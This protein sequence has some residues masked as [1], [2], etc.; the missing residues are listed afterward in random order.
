MKKILAAVLLGLCALAALYGDFPHRRFEF[1]FDFDAGASNNVLGLDKIFNIRK[2]VELDLT[3][4]KEQ[5]LRMDAAA[6]AGFFFNLKINDTY[7]IGF[8]AGGEGAGYGLANEELVRLLSRG[9][10][11]TRDFGGKIEGGAGVFVDAGLRGEARFGRLRLNLKPALFSPLIYIS[12]PDIHFENVFT[13]KGMHL[14]AVVDMD[15]YSA[16]S[17]EDDLSRIGF[18][19][20]LPLGFDIGAEGE[21]ALFPFLDLGLGITRIPVVPA[22]LSHRMSQRMSYEVVFDDIYNSFTEGDFDLPE[23]ELD[24]V[25]EDDAF[26]PV[27]RPLRVE[28]FAD[29]KPVKTDLLVI[30]PDIGFSVLTV[31][32][33]DAAC[34]NAGIRGEVNLFDIGRFYIGTGYREWVWAN[35]FGFAVNLRVFELKGE[36]RLQGPDFVNSLKPAG[37][38]AALGLRFGY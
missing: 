31:Y 3:S 23:P 30:R 13:E 10:A 24:P 26:F 5:E 38:G 15:V 7:K 27:L 37:L 25:Y 22:I 29:I 6:A 34:F 9:N 1:G 36:I 32:G 20:P 14:N 33:Y 19:S 35:S 12:K 11:A 21:Y 2:T 18:P 17:L 4:R 16:V 8:F 28:F